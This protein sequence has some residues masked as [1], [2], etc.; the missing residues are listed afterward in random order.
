MGFSGIDDSLS[1][2]G[3]TLGGAEALQWA[4]LGAKRVH[5]R[6]RRAVEE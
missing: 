5:S 3:E 4:G 1:P 2:M 6:L